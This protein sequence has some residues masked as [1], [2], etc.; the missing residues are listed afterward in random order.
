MTLHLH[1]VYKKNLQLR[2]G[3]QYYRLRQRLKQGHFILTE[4][5]TELKT[6]L[7]GAAKG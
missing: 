1:R 3:K 5:P 6:E 2:I 4:A 7:G